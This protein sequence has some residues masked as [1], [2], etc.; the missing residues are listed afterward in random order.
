M[1]E[2][3]MLKCLITK[4]EKIGEAWPPSLKERDKRVRPDAMKTERTRVRRNSR[5]YE[6]P[7]LVLKNNFC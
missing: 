1:I 5:C 6:K 4:V 2:L 3:Q 7:Q